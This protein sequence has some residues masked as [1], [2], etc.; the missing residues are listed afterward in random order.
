MM[1]SKSYNQHLKGTTLVEVLI[2]TAL[3]S[4]ILLA[5]GLIFVSGMKTKSLIDGEQ[6]IISNHSFIG[7]NISSRIIESSDISE[8]ASGSGSVLEFNSSN[9][10]EDP[11]R[12][13]LV[14]YNLFMTLGEGDP[15]QLN[16]DE[17]DVID[18]TVERLSGNP[19]AVE[20]TITYSAETF[21]G[22]SPS[23]SSTM[24][25]VLRYE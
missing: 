23:L 4:I 14:G 11:V 19:P 9:P 6:I 25:Y 7:L 21:S 3:A 17:V 22:A 2:Y 5:I 8:P 18:F 13:E 1:R 15:I 12:F 10:L 20:V 24:T 16:N